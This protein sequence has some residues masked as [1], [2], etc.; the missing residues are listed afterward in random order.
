M[1][2]TKPQ[3]SVLPAHHWPT[4]G[5]KNIV[6]IQASQTMW[7]NALPLVGKKC[8]HIGLYMQALSN[9]DQILNTCTFMI[10]NSN[11]N[12]NTKTYLDPPWTT[13]MTQLWPTTEPVVQGCLWAYSCTYH[14]AEHRP[15]IVCTLCD[16]WLQCDDPI[17]CMCFRGAR[18]ELGERGAD[19]GGGEGTRSS[20]HPRVPA[21]C[22]RGIGHSRTDHPHCLPSQTWTQGGGRLLAGPLDVRRSPGGYQR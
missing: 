1:D 4:T 11:T 19:R 17:L 2:F 15:P 5:V 6:L 13:D 20:V 12:S 7:G 9:T 16:W 10:S 22:P 14:M 21:L 18:E 8:M 3:F